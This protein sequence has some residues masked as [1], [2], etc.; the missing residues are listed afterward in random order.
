MKRL[1][2][3]QWRWLAA[4]P[5][6]AIL[7]AAGCGGDGEVAPTP[8]PTPTPIPKRPVLVSWGSFG[9]LW[10]GSSSTPCDEIRMFKNILTSLAQRQTG[11]RVL[12]ADDSACDPRTSANYCQITSDPAKLQPFFNM[13]NSIGSIEFKK[14]SSVDPY[15]YDVV[16]LDCCHTS[17]TSITPAVTNYINTAHGGMWVVGS[18][19]CLRGGTSSAQLANSVIQAYGMSFTA[20]DPGTRECLTVPAD[21]RTG[22]LQDVTS[23]DPFRVAPQ[24]VVSPAR[25]L[26]ENASGQSLVSVYER[27]VS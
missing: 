12:Y 3:T 11:V 2:W 13:I 21:R 23:I 26:L 10:A 24:T 20:L 14:Y 25:S 1:F 9:V 7:L 19:A 27:N 17:L 8:T 6:A 18:N 4:L 15:A 16:I 22:I 5:V